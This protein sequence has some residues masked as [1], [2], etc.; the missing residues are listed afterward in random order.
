[1]TSQK[2]P[3]ITSITRKP[4]LVSRHHARTS[5]SRSQQS[6]RRLIYTASSVGACGYRR[7]EALYRSIYGLLFHDQITEEL[8]IRKHKV[9]DV[10][11]WQN[12]SLPSFG[13]GFD[14]L[15]RANSAAYFSAKIAGCGDNTRFGSYFA[16]AATR[17]RHTSG[18]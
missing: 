6:S 1:M 16:L 5:G 18:P 9:V 4:G 7:L 8:I 12:R 10:V 3:I 15:P 14:P 13:R 17:R 2:E 11:Q